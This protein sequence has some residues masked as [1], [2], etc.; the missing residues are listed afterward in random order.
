MRIFLLVF[1]LL[2]LLISCSPAPPP[3]DLP[4]TTIPAP[5]VI[6]AVPE[7][8]TATPEPQ[9]ALLTRLG[10]GMPTAL[11]WSPDGRLLAVAT[12]T[13]V[14]LYDGDTFNEIQVIGADSW[15]TSLAF[16]RDG[17]YLALGQ[18]NGVARVWD[19][20]LN[21]FYR[22]LEG[23]SGTISS[24]DFSPDGSQL[25]IGR[26][27]ST[28]WI[29]RLSDGDVR[30]Q[31]HGHKDRVTAV[32]YGQQ[33][34]ATPG[35]YMLASASRDGTVLAWNSGNGRSIALFD[36]HTAAVNDLAF[37]P[38]P[39]GVDAINEKLA[40]ASDDGT[41]RF[42][43]PQSDTLL[44]TLYWFGPA[45]SEPIESAGLR[46]IGF[47]SDGGL[48]AG[49]DELGNVALW[50]AITGEPYRAF[51]AFK[52]G[53]VL[54]LAFRPGTTFL[55]V[56][57]DDGTV[58]LY[59]ANPAVNVDEPEP[60]PMRVLSDFSGAVNDLALSPDGSQLA[61]AHADGSIRLWDLS[62]GNLLATLHGH[63]GPV[64]SLSYKPSGN[65]L[66]SGGND[67]S[68]RI[69]DPT[70]LDGL[71]DPLLNTLLGHRNVVLDVAFSIDGSRIISSS[72]DGSVRSWDAE[73]GLA[74]PVLRNSQDWVYSL[75]FSPDGQW[76]VAGDARGVLQFWDTERMSAPVL[77]GEPVSAH[78]GAVQALGF[79][80]DSALLASA[81]DDALVRLWNPGEDTPLA[82]LQ[83]HTR[84]VNSL[85]FDPEGHF[86]V[87]AGEDGQVIFWSIPDGKVLFS[88]NE[89]WPVTSV[90]MG[91]AISSESRLLITGSS[92][93]SLRV[94]KISIK[95]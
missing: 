69:W 68:L 73:T 58:H 18:N 65:R 47:T 41:I 30:Q 55:A 50:N 86:L 16:S 82:N 72:A 36:Q 27:D 3:A 46:S 63:S 9:A 90:I 10:K 53:R 37:G 74:L 31:L 64:T 79:S 26:L 1:F 75:T 81:G 12:S 42:W 78:Q 7:L 38:L 92:D 52:E 13:G 32:S 91:P 89:P 61:S 45:G 24:V 77:N 80:P 20:Q 43:M 33:S 44:L 67:G 95:P 40:T 2:L 34:L 60:E 83:A 94:W 87:S 56:L 70:A 88:L 66:V 17:H 35:G 84:R 15:V 71:S 76:L 21:S 51:Q 39:A 59:N 23:S 11:A 22:S 6:T 57:G 54:D 5:H 19:F 25:A 93:G 8:P 29:W 48:L 14:Y 49:G 85:A 28:L 62:A 4:T